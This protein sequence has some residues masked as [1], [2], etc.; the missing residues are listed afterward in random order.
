MSRFTTGMLIGLGISLLIAPKP[1]REFRQLLAQTWKDI[2][3]PPSTTQPHRQSPQ[4]RGTPIPSAQEVAE[5]AAQTGKTVP[6]STQRS[7]RPTSIE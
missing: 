5:R 6:E 4:E 2:Q 1:G 7:T 3:N